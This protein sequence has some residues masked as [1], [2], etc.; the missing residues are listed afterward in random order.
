[1]LERLA[2]VDRRRPLPR[3]ARRLTKQWGAGASAEEAPI[4]VLLADTFT[5]FNEPE[6]G[7]ATR[8]VLEAFGYGV[9]LVD[10]GDMGRAAISVGRLGSAIREIDRRLESWRPMIEDES[11]QA[12]LVCE[13]SCL[14]AIR[15]DW[16]D[17][18]LRGADRAQAII[19]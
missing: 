15:D 6:I 12:F 16:L 1:M 5:C 14:S 19:G 8:R 4:V 13:P 10:A 11:N 7:L 9:R 17:L 18:S 3:Y 2:G